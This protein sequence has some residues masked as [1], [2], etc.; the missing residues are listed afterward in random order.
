MPLINPYPET[1]AVNAEIDKI[2]KIYSDGF[3]IYDTAERISQSIAAVG[4]L[5]QSLKHELGIPETASHLKKNSDDIQLILYLERMEDALIPCADV[6]T[7]CET[8]LRNL[9]T[10]LVSV[11]YKQVIPQPADDVNNRKITESI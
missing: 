3:E 2:N 6:L 5:L 9:R 4:H 10:D 1:E 8:T 11:N 7:K